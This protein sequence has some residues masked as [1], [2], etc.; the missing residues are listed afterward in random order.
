MGEGGGGRRHHLTLESGEHLLRLYAYKSSPLRTGLFYFLSIATFGIFRLVLHWKQKWHIAFRATRSTFAFADFIYIIDDHDVEEFHPIETTR[1][2]F[3]APPL[4][5]PGEDGSMREVDEIRWFVYRRLHYIWVEREK[6]VYDDND[7]REG[8]WITPGDVMSQSPPHIFH[9]AISKG[10]GFNEHQVSQRLATYGLNS[11]EINLR[12]VP[13][14][15]F[16]EAISPFY[17]FQIFRCVF[18][19]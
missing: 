17:I 7:E 6:K 16:M 13:V 4:V 18:R 9:E 1:R 19:M 11:I 8:E 10:T 2:S 3:R 14:L 12:P 5:V 15:L